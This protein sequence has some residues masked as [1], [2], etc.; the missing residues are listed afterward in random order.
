M[1]TLEEHQ[2][3]Y[4]NAMADGNTLAAIKIKNI[5]ENQLKAERQQ[6]SSKEKVEFNEDSGK[7]EASFF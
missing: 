2:K 3:A 4:K 6:P 1:P 5:Y 7:P